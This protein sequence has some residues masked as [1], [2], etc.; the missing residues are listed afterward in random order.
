MSKINILCV[1]DQREVLAAI[2]KDLEF[3]SPAFNIEDC[4]SASEAWEVIN[5]MVNQG[6]Q[7]AVIVC[8]HIMPG[9]NGIDFLT[10]INQDGRFSNTKRI[11]LTGLATHQE[12]I[13]A[14]NE[15]QINAYLEK[16]WDSDELIANVK[17]L[18]AT[19]FARTK[20][21]HSQ[22]EEYIDADTLKRE[23]D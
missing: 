8:D 16:P 18:L 15:A 23:L 11:L 13:R 7:V 3:F 9:D 17:K 20:Q 4:E 19:Y 14:I 12:T 5:D 10:Q 6:E 22:F 2:K 21:D 1:D